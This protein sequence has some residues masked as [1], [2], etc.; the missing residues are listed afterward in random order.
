MTPPLL[1]CV[2]TQ[3][4]LWIKGVDHAIGASTV[5]RRL[6]LELYYNNEYTGEMLFNDEWL[7]ELCQGLSCNRSIE[8][9]SLYH[10]LSLEVDPFQVLAP[11]SSTT[12]NSAT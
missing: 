12:T 1:D 11:S 2:L 3:V 6:Q 5:L 8:C 4:Y 7:P 9:L 10:Q